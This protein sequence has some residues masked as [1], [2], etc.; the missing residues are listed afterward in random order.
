MYIQQIT[1][2]FKG[3]LLFLYKNKKEEKIWKE[4]LVLVFN[5]NL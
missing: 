2:N 4:I 1:C 5:N 3:C